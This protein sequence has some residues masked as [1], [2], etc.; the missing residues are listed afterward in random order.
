MA[1]MK[2]VKILTLTKFNR[3]IKTEDLMNKIKEYLGERNVD[4]TSCAHMIKRE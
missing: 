3:L 1:E 2:V 4:I